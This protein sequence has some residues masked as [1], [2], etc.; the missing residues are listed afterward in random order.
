MIVNF[1][2]STRVD[3]P[4]D[5]R[6]SP[7]YPLML[8]EFDQVREPVE[9]YDLDEDQW[10]RG[11]VAGTAEYASVEADLRLRLLEWMQSTDDPLLSGPVV[12]PYYL[13]ALSRLRSAA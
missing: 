4:T 9:K 8:A 3:V 6:E 2:V 10:E 13:D 11:N 5:I 12:S 7:M 1:E